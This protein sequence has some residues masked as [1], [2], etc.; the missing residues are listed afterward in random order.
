ML[1]L[2]RVV[3]AEVRREFEGF[4]RGSISG[5]WGRYPGRTPTHGYQNDQRDAVIIPTT[6]GVKNCLDP[7]IGWG[8]VQSVKIVS[9]CFSCIFHLSKKV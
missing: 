1:D 9:C 2:N 6:S 7:Q 4:G 5:Q 8:V 3:V